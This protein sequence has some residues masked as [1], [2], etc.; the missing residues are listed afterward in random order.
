[1]ELMDLV[2]Q[3]RPFMPMG[4]GPKINPDA[5]QSLPTNA[6][7]SS[8]SMQPDVSKLASTYN[9]LANA[10]GGPAN[11]AYRDFLDKDIP[12]E[13]NFKPSPVQRIGAILSGISATTQG[14]DGYSTAR[15]IVDEPYDSEVG[16]WKLR[17]DKLAKGADLEEKDIN[18]RVKTYRDIMES[19]D[20]QDK[21][22]ISDKRADAYLFSKTH[23][24]WKPQA[25]PGG[26]LIYVNPL[27]PTQTYDTGY[28]SG[29]MNEQDKIA[30]LNSGK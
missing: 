16:R 27:D 2:R 11:K 1:M 12:Q 18:N 4:D 29:K 7:P 30:L 9:D 10:S 17:G 19:Q 28:E 3:M 21:N 8:Q 6:I 22:A 5:L 26:N 14:K 24:E 20:R 25:M 23:P 15:N 13:N